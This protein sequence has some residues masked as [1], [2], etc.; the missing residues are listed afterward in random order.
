MKRIFLIFVAVL[1]GYTANAQ[2]VQSSSLMVTTVKKKLPPVERGYEQ[3]VDLSFHKIGNLSGFNLNYIG[4]MRFNN[5]IFLGI[6]TGLNIAPVNSGDFVRE[7]GNFLEPSTVY[8]PLYAHFRYYMMKK[9]FSPFLALSL[10]GAF[11]G[12]KNL[13][14]ELGPVKY[15]TVGLLFNPQVGFNLRMTAKSSIYLSA[16][17]FTQTQPFLTEETPTSAVVESLLRG[18][19]DFHLGFTF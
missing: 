17:A 9:R 15:S 2:L 13:E 4:G 16:G 5:A 19:I 10:G 8:I 18:G 1:A 3:S 14:L 6:G 12:S 7:S 11:S